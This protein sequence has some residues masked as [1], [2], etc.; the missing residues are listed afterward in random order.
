MGEGEAAGDEVLLG[1]GP[2]VHDLEDPGLE[3]GDDGNVVGRDAVL[4]G[5]A[6]DDHLGDLGLAVDGLVGEVEV[7]RHGAVAGLGRGRHAPG[8]PTGNGGEGSSE[9]KHGWGLVASQRR[10][11][12][13]WRR[14]TSGRQ[15]SS[16]RES[17]KPDQHRHPTIGKRDYPLVT[18][19]NLLLVDIYCFKKLVF[20]SNL[21]EKHSIKETSCPRNPRHSPRAAAVPSKMARRRDRTLGCLLVLWTNSRGETC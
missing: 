6:G 7:E 20:T 17:E 8:H 9:G 14:A 1:L 2:L 3:L 13:K 21:K 19:H 12:R 18:T 5:G 15:K 4:S 16:E 11:R 10:N